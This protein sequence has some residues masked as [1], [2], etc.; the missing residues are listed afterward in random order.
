MINKGEPGMA[1]GRATGE[2]REDGGGGEE[3]G[4]ERQ[5]EER[6]RGKGGRRGDAYVDSSGGDVFG[7]GVGLVR[8]GRT[9][10][11][12][13]RGG[14]ARRMERAGRARGGV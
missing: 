1:K 9:E 11:A 13:R 12:R 10:G 3:D 4:G 5:G 2:G 7:A 6:R 14:G 8:R